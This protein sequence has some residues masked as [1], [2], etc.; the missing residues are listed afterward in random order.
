MST[1][2]I[3]TGDKGL[4]R[5]LRKFGKDAEKSIENVIKFTAQDAE[6][7]AKQFAPSNKKTTGGDLKQ[8]IK[9]R[10]IKPLHSVVEANAF[11]SPYVEFGTGKLVDVPE[12]F[13]DQAIQFKGAGI[14][15]VNI[16]PQPFMY[17]AYKIAEQNYKKDLDDQLQFLTNKFNS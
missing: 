13:R 3:I 5:A 8:M 10:D 4:I 12:I 2:V 9:A 17:P 15:E 16:Y 14:K 6:K 7:N 1:R 11:Y